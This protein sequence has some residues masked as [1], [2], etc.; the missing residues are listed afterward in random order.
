[1]P[2]V[3]THV[4]GDE[5]SIHNHETWVRVY[6]FHCPQCNAKV[7]MSLGDSG[8]GLCDCSGRW[9][10]LVTAILYQDENE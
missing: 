3:L 1:M 4:T 2:M 5:I 9:E 10:V 6:T 8:Y 7:V